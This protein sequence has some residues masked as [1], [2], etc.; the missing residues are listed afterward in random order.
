MAFHSNQ[1]SYDI[2]KEYDEVI[3]AQLFGH[4]HSDEFRVGLADKSESAA[5]ISMI[6]LMDTPILLG[7]SVTPLHG[8]NPS[9][10]LVN[11]GLGGGG[12]ESNN[13][14]Y[15]ILDYDS[16]YCDIEADN[17]WSKLYTFSEA[18]SVASDI[19]EKDGLTSEAFVTIVKSMEDKWGK[20]S[21]VLKTFR[22]YQLSGAGGNG[23][24]QGANVNC[25]P[26]CRDDFICTFQ[27]ATRSGYDN[28]LL[29]RKHSW[30]RD[31]RTIFGI[32][33]AVMFGII[34]IIF[35]II[36]RGKERR[37]YESPGSVPDDVKNLERVDLDE[38]VI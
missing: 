11:Y 4:L 3:I 7:P 25:D 2:V 14:K 18:Y 16:Y 33:G 20:E 37:Y 27:A 29:E 31:G 35:V 22:S 5:P 26:Q 13:M 8:N 21:P 9:F 15:R 12:S 36:R 17:H 30:K 32:V 1:F 6:P 34:L 10:R 38:D 23:G 19:I 28:C 24:S